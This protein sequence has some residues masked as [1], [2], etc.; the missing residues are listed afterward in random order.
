MEQHLAEL[1]PLIIG[2]SAFLIGI[3]FAL[4]E[5]AWRAAQRT[6]NQDRAAA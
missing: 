4:R 3:F 5:R 6:S 2:T 1:T